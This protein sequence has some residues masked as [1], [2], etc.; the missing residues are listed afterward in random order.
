MN[1][2]FSR[3]VATV[4]FCEIMQPAAFICVICVICAIC[5]RITRKRTQAICAIVVCSYLPLHFPF[6][7][8][9][10]RTQLIFMKNNI[11]LLYI[12][13]FL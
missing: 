12:K 10:Q 3:S 13:Y 2:I 6:I 4:F 9:S 5:E 1:Y 8:V 7:F 11:V